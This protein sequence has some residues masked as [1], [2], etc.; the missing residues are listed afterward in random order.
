MLRVYSFILG[1][2]LVAA[3][4]GSQEGTSDSSNIDKGVL[5]D[6]QSEVM[7]EQAPDQF[8]ARFE[9]SAGD[10]TIAVERDLAPQGADRFYNLV[11]NGYY[12]G[13]RFFRVLPGFVVQWGMHGDPEVMAQWQNARIPDD[14]VKDSNERGTITFAKT[15]APNSR[16]TQLFINLGNNS[17]SLDRQGFAPFGRVTDGMQAVDAINAEYEQRPDQGQIG[18]RGNEYLEE[19]FPNLDYIKTASIVD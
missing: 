9:T 10:F 5:M 18:A 1:M 13:Q 19:K 14:P 7:K 2:A 3:G 4:C 11:K 8:A 12:D 15:G 16:S 17:S 6:P